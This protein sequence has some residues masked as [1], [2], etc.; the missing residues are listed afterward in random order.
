M[1]LTTPNCT[2]K[3]GGALYRQELCLS[4]LF[5]PNTNIG[6]DRDFGLNAY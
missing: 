5:V 4:Y 1:L 2:L 3:D 6:P